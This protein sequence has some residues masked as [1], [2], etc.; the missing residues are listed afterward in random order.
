MCF[1]L[2]TAVEREAKNTAA[3]YSLLV[4]VAAMAYTAH[5]MYY[6]EVAYT[7]SSTRG[8]S[9]VVVHEH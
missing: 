9:L 8:S 3:S 6:S 2:H 5:I 1:I 4:G 7:S